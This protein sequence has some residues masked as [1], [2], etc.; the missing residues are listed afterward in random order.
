MRIPSTLPVVALVA[1][2]TAAPAAGQT[3]QSEVA[4]D[5]RAVGDKY[6]ALAEAMPVATYDWRPGE[7]VRSVSEVFMHIAA[8]NLGLPMNFMQVTPPPG[9]AQ[10]WFGT[11]EEISDK[12]S[13]VAHL[14]VAF[15]HLAATI[16]GLT[17]AQLAQPVNVFGR[18]TNWMGAVLLLQTHSHEHLGQA[19]AYARTN[20]VT[21]PWSN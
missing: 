21:P 18:D 12:E 6:V 2:L 7:G 9:Y 11:A 13:V 1:A 19:I 14:G 17:D 20:G 3:F 15:E 10:D 5:L 16:E 4:F 8:A